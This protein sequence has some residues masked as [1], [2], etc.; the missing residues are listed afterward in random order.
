M[1]TVTKM[2]SLE[3]MIHFFDALAVSDFGEACDLDLDSMGFYCADCEA[4]YCEECWSIGP[5][6]F[7]DD[8]EGF[9]DTL[10]GRARRGIGTSWTIE[11]NGTIFA[12]PVLA[13]VRAKARGH[14]EHEVIPLRELRAF[15]SSW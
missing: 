2:E 14:K 9:Y 13:R 5:P 3:K 10:R 7:D 11:Y 1:G 4:V 15:V 6:V 8:F 12:T